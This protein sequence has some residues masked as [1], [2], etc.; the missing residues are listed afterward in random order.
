MTHL[1]INNEHDMEASIETTTQL[2]KLDNTSVTLEFP[3]EEFA[4]IFMENLFVSMKD[5]G[6]KKDT[7]MQLQVIF[8]V[9]EDD[10][11]RT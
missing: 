2:A 10:D 6:I 4:N 7:K 11:D 5:A 8:P 9:E 3:S 1:I